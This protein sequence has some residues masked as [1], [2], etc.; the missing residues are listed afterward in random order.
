M[1]IRKLERKLETLMKIKSTNKSATVL[2]NRIERHKN[3]LL[4]FVKHKDVEYHNNRA[5]RTIRAVVIFRKLS[6]GSRTHEG[7][8]YYAMLSSV[9][10]TCRLKGKS[11]LVFVKDVLK[12]P[13]DQLHAV[14]KSLLDTS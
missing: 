8:Q 3:E 12:T 7:T 11:I 1:E 13:D 9:L 2:V 5:E 10:E 4:R 6:F 14:T